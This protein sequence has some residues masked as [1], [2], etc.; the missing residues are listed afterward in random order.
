MAAVTTRPR[1][2]SCAARLPENSGSSELLDT[3]STRPSGSEHILSAKSAIAPVFPVRFNPSSA[4]MPSTSE[5][6][7]TSQA[8][9]LPM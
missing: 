5:E 4:A 3:I 2:D 9:D 7:M 1:F 8:S 6:S